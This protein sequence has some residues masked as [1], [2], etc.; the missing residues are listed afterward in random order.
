[1]IEENPFRED[2]PHFHRPLTHTSHHH[3]HHSHSHRPEQRRALFLC[4]LITSLMMVVEVI[5]GIYTGSLMLLSDAIHMFSH[6]FSLVVSYAAV[7]LAAKPASTRESFG[8]FR[9]EIL[10]ALVNAIGLAFFSLWIVYESILRIIEPVP[11]LGKELTFVAIAGLIVNLGTA[12]LLGRAG[13]EDLNTRSAFLHMLTDTISSVAI[14]LGGIFIVFTGW[15]LIDPLLS[16]L[17]AL[18]V[19]R[20]ASD[21]LRNSLR[22]LIEATPQNIDLVGIQKDI[23][24]YSDSIRRVHDLHV[25]EITSQFVCLTAHLEISDMKLSEADLI[26]QKIQHMLNEKYHIAHSVIQIESFPEER[27]K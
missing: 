18:L 2:H 25:W 4:V 7:R 22:I 5:A 11:I 10:A 15:Y 19:A 26:R 8:F 12:Y 20:W 24:D 16:L 14:V 1:M 6:A 27:E 3:H 13:T 17:I 9:V 23:D 21:L